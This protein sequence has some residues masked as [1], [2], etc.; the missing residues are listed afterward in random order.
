MQN[1]MPKRQC[2]NLPLENVHRKIIRIPES[3][4]RFV[5]D[6]YESAQP[7]TKNGGATARH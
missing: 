5:R 4:A 3:L 6:I 7:F 2:F 1:V